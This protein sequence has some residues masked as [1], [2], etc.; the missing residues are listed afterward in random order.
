MTNEATQKDI[1]NACLADIDHLT[2]KHVELFGTIIGKVAKVRKGPNA[3]RKIRIDFEPNEHCLDPDGK[4]LHY[5]PCKGMI[6]VLAKAWGKNGSVDWIG[7]SMELFGNPDVIYA[8]KKKGGIQISRLSHI[9]KPLETQLTISQG[10]TVLFRVEPL[11]TPKPEL[12]R[13]EKFRGW[14]KRKE[15]PETDATAQIGDR[16]L[17]DATEEDWA[18]LKTWTEQFTKGTP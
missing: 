5:L 2:Y 9:D 10:S 11:P 15:L 17:E 8:G 3:K 1:E 18:T 6:R 13:I 16:T 12:S 7:K 14:L 4:P